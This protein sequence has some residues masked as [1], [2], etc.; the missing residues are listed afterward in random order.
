MTLRVR[1]NSKHQITLP[2][3]VR[4]QLGIDTGDRFL[5]T[6]R[7]GVIILIPEPKG[8]VEELRGLYREIWEGVD[9]QDYIDQER[10][11]W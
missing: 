11:A 2:A 1:M 5:V 8:A 9:V 7:D 10:D 6:I 4:Q 3:T